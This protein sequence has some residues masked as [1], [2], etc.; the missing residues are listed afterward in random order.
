MNQT[1]T[2]NQTSSVSEIRRE[3]ERAEMMERIMDAARAM[4]VQ[5][6]YGAVTL[7]K[8]ALAIEY[9]PGAIYQYFKD[10]Q[11]LVKAIIQKDQ[12]DLRN[13][14]M[15]CMLFEEPRARLIEMARRY[16]QWGVSHPNHYM[17]LLAPPSSWVKQENELRQDTPTPLEQEAIKIL[18]ES[19]KD[20][21]RRG[22]FKDKYANPSLI[23]AT[24]WA[25]IHG[26]IM[27]EIGLTEYDRSLIGEKNLSFDDKFDMLKEV[28]LDGLV[29]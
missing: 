10:K 3:R 28:F 16:A 13:Q 9:S 14:I 17:L 7:R 2:D 12:Q 22:V 5:D 24:L 21:M 18:Y 6:G 29:K 11:T 23:A 27:L 8:I 4:F 26:V 1:I 20:A 19:V 25:G 15:A